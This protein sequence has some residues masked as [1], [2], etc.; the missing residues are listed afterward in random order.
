MSCGY[1]ET[2][3][4]HNSRLLGGNARTIV[5]FPANIGLFCKQPTHR[6]LGRLPE[7]FERLWAVNDPLYAA[8]TESVPGRRA[9]V[10]RELAGDS[11]LRSLF[12][13]AD[14]VRTPS[15]VAAITRRLDHSSADVETR[16]ACK[17]IANTSLGNRGEPIALAK[18]AERT[19]ARVRQ[20]I[21][22]F[23]RVCAVRPRRYIL[24]IAGRIDGV[25]LHA[26]KQEDAGVSEPCRV[27]HEHEWVGEACAEV[28]EVKTRTRNLFRDMSDNE[29]IQLAMYLE[30]FNADRGV[31]VEKFGDR[32]MTHHYVRDHAFYR[33][34][35]EGV[36]RFMDIFVKFLGSL[37]ARQRYLA[38]SDSSR[39]A[40]ICEMIAGKRSRWLL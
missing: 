32:I 16:L 6:E 8:F 29:K 21:H 2:M 28:I 24:E 36:C 12:D 23:S 7:V 40:A 4:E 9:C 11:A 35:I 34:I 27:E 5:V 30:I 14:A 18:Y 26:D 39:C 22:R 20:P 31:L 25:V 19:G 3:T 13:S 1:I 33:H 37:E 38:L 10:E 17:T 15:D